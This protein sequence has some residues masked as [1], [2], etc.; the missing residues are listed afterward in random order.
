MSKDIV[1]H[2]DAQQYVSEPMPENAKRGPAVTLLNATPDPLGSIAALIGVY[3]GK[4]HRSLSTVTDEER[5]G[6]L[7]DMQA[8]VLSGPLEAV[9]FQFLIEGVGRDFT[10]QAVRGRNAFYAQESLRFAVKEDWVAETPYP[11]S[12]AGVPE[13]DGMADP[14]EAQR[15]T[16]VWDNALDDAGEGYGRLIEL[17]VPAEDARKLLPHAVTTRYMWICSLRELLH[18]A[19]V[20][21]CTQAQFE[22]RIVMG[23]IA[24]ALR[25]WGNEQDARWATEDVFHLP[26]ERQDGWQFNLLADALRPACYQTGSCAFKAQFDR[27]CKIRDRVDMNEHAMRPSAE[28][29]RD[30][31]YS[32]PDGIGGKVQVWIAGINPAEWATDPGAARI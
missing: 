9:T 8:T 7:A 5:R 12:L 4:I 30:A 19:G 21:T 31:W 6:A 11:P 28:W 1:R 10:H 23:Q 17:G 29:H 14:T 20:R 13:W 25:D 3:K 24:K 32:I 27:A 22:W 16:E 26:I 15:A 18:V 2:A